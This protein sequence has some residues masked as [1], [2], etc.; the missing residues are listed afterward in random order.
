MTKTADIIALLPLIGYFLLIFLFHALLPASESRFSRTN[1]SRQ[2]LFRFLALGSLGIT[3]YHMLRFIK[4]S[5]F[6]HSNAPNPS[7]ESIA[8]WLRGTALF[9]EA[10]AFF[11]SHESS[12]KSADCLAVGPIQP[13]SGSTIS[14]VGLTET[15]FILAGKLFRYSSYGREKHKNDL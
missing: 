6:R 3:W 10:W 15:D 8:A 9:E 11:T 7:I 2:L 5:Y 4:W 12:A 13:C 14:Y 1:S